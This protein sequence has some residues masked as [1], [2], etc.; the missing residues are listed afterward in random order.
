MQVSNVKGIFKYL[1]KE[2]LLPFPVTDLRA[3]F[4][5]LV[6]HNISSNSQLSRRL[7]AQGRG[8]EK[9]AATNLAPHP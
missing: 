6:L 3:V 9:E 5:F 7:L 2:T 1:G 4:S 8:L